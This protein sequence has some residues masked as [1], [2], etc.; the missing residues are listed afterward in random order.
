MAATARLDGG[1]Q[2]KEHWLPRRQPVAKT[3]AQMMSMARASRFRRQ[4]TLMEGC[5]H[6]LARLEEGGD[7][8]HFRGHS[9][10]VTMPEPRP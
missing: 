7:L 3:M 8:S 10:A 4:S 1:E 5:F 2:H 9:V 6:L